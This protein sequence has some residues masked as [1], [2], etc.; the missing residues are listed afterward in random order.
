MKRVVMFSGG[1]GS[2]AAAKRVVERHGASDVTLLFADTKSEHPDTYRFL[3][4]AAV[5]IGAPLKEITDERYADI[6]D[7][8]DKVGFLGN[9]R[10]DP[11]SRIFK[12]ERSDRWLTENCDPE[13]TTIYVGIDWTEEHRFTRMRDRKLPWRYEAPLCEKPF[14]L[15]PDLHAWAEREGLRMQELY[16]LGA[17]HANCGGLCVKMGHGGFAHGL[18]TDRANYLRWEANEEA[19]Q[20]KHGNNATILR[21]RRG[22]VTVP[23]SLKKFRL[24][25]EAGESCDLFDI[26]G[27]NCF[28]EPELV[29]IGDATPKEP[30][31]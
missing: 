11:C 28:G 15:K 10:V 3:R 20:E 19:F 13:D 18:K 1:I 29:A 9:T 24:R 25:I 17:S 16:R 31:G 14:L 7:L 4:E 26:G 22:G 6:F 2:W 27:C 23:L 21:D 5:N 8:F 30:K 12:R